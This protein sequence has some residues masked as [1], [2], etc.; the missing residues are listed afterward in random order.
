MVANSRSKNCR[1]KSLDT[2]RSVRLKTFGSSSIA[3][4]NI[5]SKSTQPKKRVFIAGRLTIGS[6]AAR[7]DAKDMSLSGRAS[8][9]SFTSIFHRR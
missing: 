1:R 6:S 4:P 8:Q 2:G 7:Q 5:P 3:S 9:Q